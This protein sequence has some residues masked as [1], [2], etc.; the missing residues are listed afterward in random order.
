VIDCTAMMAERRDVSRF[1]VPINFDALMSSGGGVVIR[2]RF[3]IVKFRISASHHYL[4]KREAE[5]I[6]TLHS[7]AH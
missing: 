3:G 7:L 1:V 4:N 2:I 5:Q 6:L